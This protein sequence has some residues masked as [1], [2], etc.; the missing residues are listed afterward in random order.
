S[1]QES[2]F[3]QKDHLWK[4]GS[5]GDR[6]DR[7]PGYLQWDL[8]GRAWLLQQGRWEKTVERHHLAYL[9]GVGATADGGDAGPSEGTRI[10]LGNSRRSINRDHRH[11]HSRREKDRA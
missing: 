10:F 5:Q 3:R 11:D 9:P 8:A 7:G 4:S 2:E 1:I 6:D